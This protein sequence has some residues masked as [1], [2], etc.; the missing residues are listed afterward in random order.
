MK[1]NNW[2]LIAKHKLRK[3]I[4]TLCVFLCCLPLTTL[5]GCGAISAVKAP[6]E[7]AGFMKGMVTQLKEREA[8]L[9]ESAEKPLTESQGELL[10]QLLEEKAGLDTV[11]SSQPYLTY[12]EEQIGA[13]HKDYPT[14]LAAVPTTEQKL[15]LLFTFKEILPP[16]ATDEQIQISMNFY[17]QFCELIVNEPDVAYESEEIET[18]IKIHLIDPLMDTYPSKMSTS[19][20]LKVM[21]MGAVPTGMAALDTEVLRKVWVKHLEVYGSREGLLRCAISTPDEFALIRSFFEEAAALETWIRL[22]P[23]QE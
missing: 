5:L 4:P 16:E 23:K 19:D 2:L 22:P 13:A 7:M 20:A 10:T 17:F 6:F 11:L 12:L 21:K 3:Q 8:F 1:R 18:F 15:T 14:Y 9:I